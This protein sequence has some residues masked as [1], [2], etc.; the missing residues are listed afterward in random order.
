M[1][2]K[3]ELLKRLEDISDFRVDKAKIEYALHEVLFI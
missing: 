1:K 3:K 2:L